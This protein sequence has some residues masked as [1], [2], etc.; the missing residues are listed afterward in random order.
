MTPRVVVLGASGF[1]GATLVAQLAERPVL[2]RAVARR[3]AV[4][5][6][7]SAPAHTE[8]RSAD[9]T[10]RTA[11]AEAVAD[12][13]AVVHLVTH[14]D[15]QGSWR[16]RDGDPVAE[17][18]NV[19]VL[20][21]LLEILA[22]RPRSEGAPPPTVLFAS[23]A[24]L[25]AHEPPPTAPGATPPATAAAGPLT[26]YD[27]Q[28]YAAELALRAA[29]LA[30]V[31]RGV[32]LRLPTVF[33]PAVNPRAPDRGVVS[34]MVRRALEGEPLTLWADGSLRR[35]LLPVADAARGFLAALD[36]A[37]RLAGRSWT[38]GAD[39][40]SSLGEVFEQVAALVAEYTG[41][42]PVPVHRTAP[43]TGAATGSDFRD[44]RVDAA[45]FRAVTGWRPLLDTR[46]ALEAT[47][48]ALV[49]PPGAPP[50]MSTTA[51]PA[52]TPA[53]EHDLAS[54]NRRARPGEQQAP[55]AANAPGTARAL[56]KD[57]A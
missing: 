2:L 53:A 57:S 18:T 41:R 48:A 22:E 34:A 3:P 23:T 49:P 8:I 55:A 33:G 24:S 14:R 10:D 39:R 50:P 43:P 31:V 1:L 6:A 17:H 15:A 12:A 56:G 45:P 5:P 36:H 25:D 9:L 54:G 44:V 35:N 30:G 28:K 29:D 20:R 37:D 27:R 47:V 21:D 19:T 38:L 11:L 13:D 16:T 26:G 46:T 7:C 4:P 52:A 40:D 51:A 42:P 32:A